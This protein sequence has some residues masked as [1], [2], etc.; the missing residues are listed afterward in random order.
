[1]LYLAAARQ[2]NTPACQHVYAWNSDTPII[3]VVAFYL[4]EAHVICMQYTTAYEL[5]RESYVLSFTQ[6]SGHLF[7]LAVNKLL[8]GVLFPYKRQYNVRICS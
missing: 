2:L 3:N 1:M 5:W 8:Q 7:H 4:H 6:I